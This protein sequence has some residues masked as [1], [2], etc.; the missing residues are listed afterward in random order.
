MAEVDEKGE[1]VGPGGLVTVAYL[2]AQ[3][4]S[5]GDLLSI[6]M[7]LVLDVLR[8]SSS[9]SFAASDVQQ[10]LSSLHGLAVPIPTLTT[11]LR[12]A[13]SMGLLRREAGRFWKTGLEREPNTDVEGEKSAIEE[14]QSLLGRAL[15]EHAKRR[16]I[17]LPT[18]DD[19]LDALLD[20][21][22]D[23]HVSMLLEAPRRAVGSERDGVNRAVV[24]E[25][26]RDVVAPDRAMSSVLSTLL[27]GLVVYHAVF[28]PH[29]NPAARTFKDLTI[30]LDSVLVR[31]AIG[32][33][34]EA[35]QALMS[36]TIEVLKA[37]NVSCIVFDKTVDE[38][39]RIL[40][41]YETKLATAAGRQSLHPVPMARHFL[42]KR[43]APS[44]VR[45]MSALLEKDIAA[46][47]IRVQRLPSRIPEFTAREADLAKRLAR[48]DS[49]DEQEPRVVHDVD[50]VAGVLVMR[51][52]HRSQS[53]EDA[54][55]V[56]ATTSPLVIQNTRLW[57]QHDERGSGIEPIVHVRALAN[58]AWLKRVSMLQDY[59]LRELIALCSAAMKPGQATWERFLKHLRTLQESKKLSSDEVTAIVVSSLSDDLLRKAEI[60]YD[61]G[62]DL[63]ATVLDEIVDRVKASYSEDALRQMRILEEQNSVKLDQLRGEAAVANARAI[64]AEKSAEEIRRRY[65][66]QLERRS[67]FWGRLGRRVAEWTLGLLVAGGGL[68]LV[69]GHH[70]PGGWIGRFVGFAVIA[71]VLLELFG[72]LKHVAELGSWV[73][74]QIAQTVRNMLQE[75]GGRRPSRWQR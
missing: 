33:E 21:V 22:N 5:G 42:T 24:A 66:L 56:F 6:F 3:L 69:L 20:F 37:A 43:Y 18:V 29:I 2:K 70:T 15:Q 40:A 19:A 49:Q 10:F 28:Q 59:K 58:L 14:G 73:E 75:E 13:V 35:A 53:I 23:E 62:E 8:K 30:V 4:D 50:C 11:L 74:V 51:R 41:M 52:G 12:R 31:Q 36:E 32:F 60:E 38:I 68:E 16:G 7:P 1:G 65:A 34:G 67:A 55:A 57:W 39:R 27:E 72:I 44:D 64:E 46:A 17:D 25:F 48:P 71:F 61:D 47:G 45:Q 9:N 54:R 26:V 63:D